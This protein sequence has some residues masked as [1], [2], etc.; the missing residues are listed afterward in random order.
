MTRTKETLE[1]AVFNQG[2]YWAAEGHASAHYVG[3][4]MEAL[5][6]LQC[7]WKDVSAPMRAGVLVGI[8]ALGD[9][10]GSYADD[11]LT[12]KGQIIRRLNLTDA[13][14]SLYSPEPPFS[15]EASSPRPSA[16]AISASPSARRRRTSTPRNRNSR[17]WRLAVSSMLSTSLLSS[18]S[19]TAYHANQSHS[20]VAATPNGNCSG[21]IPERDSKDVLV[22]EEILPVSPRGDR[23]VE[24]VVGVGRSFLALAGMEVISQDLPLEVIASMTGATE[25]VL[26]LGTA[27]V[28]GEAVQVNMSC[29]TTSL[30]ESD[31]GSAKVSV[32]ANASDVLE[33]LNQLDESTSLPMGISSE[34]GNGFALADRV[35]RKEQMI[36]KLEPTL[37]LEEDSGQQQKK[38]QNE[39]G[40]GSS[41]ESREA[42][43][44]DTVPTEPIGL[45]EV[46][47]SHRRS[48]GASNSVSQ[49]ATFSALQD[50]VKDWI[51][52]LMNSFAKM[53]FR[54][55]M[56][57]DKIQ[58]GFLAVHELVAGGWTAKQML[59]V[60]RSLAAMHI[61]WESLPHDT[62]RKTLEALARK[63]QGQGFSVPSSDKRTGAVPAA[64]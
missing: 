21:S 51:P 28:T 32:V 61:P 62:R 50:V 33:H 20:N 24:Y 25:R 41:T 52:K 43:C 15:E 16:T 58:K 46:D 49:P 47:V 36:P 2:I 27:E 4:V 44:K 31:G 29:D 23:D 38:L 57:S 60:M 59:M 18:P 6:K 53:G 5:R 37:L 13:V 63:L 8:R 1:T 17:G 30:I 64:A 45:G 9:F 22:V 19:S 55:N 12:T 54:H 10:N 11:A 14:L 34:D 35:E 26:D 42:I 7:K 40:S 39:Y 3:E 56:L 48:E